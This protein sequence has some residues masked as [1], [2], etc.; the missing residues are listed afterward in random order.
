MAISA[1]VLASYNSV[2][3]GLVLFLNHN[4]FSS[5]SCTFFSQLWLFLITDGHFGFGPKKRAVDPSAY[6]AVNSHQCLS[7]LPQGSECPNLCAEWKKHV[8][9]ECLR[10]GLSLRGSELHFNWHQSMHMHSL[11]IKTA[12]KHLME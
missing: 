4:V 9:G 7:Y 6:K 5:S 2:D 1:N 11:S 3:A 12:S 8:C 10:R